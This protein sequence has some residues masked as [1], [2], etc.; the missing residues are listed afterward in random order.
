M[1]STNHFASSELRDR[2]WDVNS[3]HD[4]FKS[5]LEARGKVLHDSVTF[6]RNA[7]EVR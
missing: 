7:D 6:F 1:L 5:R 2:M 4:N 3:L